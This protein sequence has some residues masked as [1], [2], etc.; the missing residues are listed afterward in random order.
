MHSER[1][2]SINFHIHI[3]STPHKTY[4]VTLGDCMKVTTNIP[5]CL[6]EVPPSLRH[7]VGVVSGLVQADIHVLQNVVVGRQHLWVRA[8]VG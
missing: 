2:E 4:Q 7:D 3:S 6:H 5:A 8:K 1:N